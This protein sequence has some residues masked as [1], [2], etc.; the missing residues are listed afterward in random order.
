MRFTQFN[1]SDYKYDLL[2]E[3]IYNREQEWFHYDF[4]KQNFEQMIATT[5]NDEIKGQMQ[6]RLNETLKQMSIV[7]NIHSALLAQI[8]D[9][10]AYQAA[11][12]RAAVKRAAQSG[13]T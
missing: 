8:T 13:Q 6:Q 12:E 9:Q 4:D 7:E 1:S 11:V 5:D 3:N 2:A 10:A